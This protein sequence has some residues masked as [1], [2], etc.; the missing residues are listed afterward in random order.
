MKVLAD[1]PIS[2]KTVIYLNS[3]GYQGIRVDRLEMQK[4]EDEEIINYAYEN[5]M[6]IL[7]MD[8]DF[9]AILAHLGWGKPS[10]I[11][12]RLNNPDINQVNTLLNKILREIKPDLER[13]VIVIVEEDRVRIR[14]LP[15]EKEL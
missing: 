11:I 12:F 3:L 13:G 8:L 6:V 9:G 2:P 7:T 4:A 14:D 5:D 15:I 10:V 1:M